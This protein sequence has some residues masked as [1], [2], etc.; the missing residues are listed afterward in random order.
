VSSA[1]ILEVIQGSLAETHGLKPGDHIVS[2][3]GRTL[4]DI[5]DY[6]FC[7]ADNHLVLELVHESERRFVRIE[8]PGFES[9]GLR[10]AT[11]LFDGIKTCANKCVFC[12]IDQL[13]PGMRDAVYV[14]D[15]DFRLSFLYGNFVTLTNMRDDDIDRIIDDRLS[16]L[17]V[18]I[19]AT[20]PELR[21]RMLG[22]KKTDTTLERLKRLSDADIELHIQMVMCPGL[23]DKREL[24]GSIEYLAN[25]YD[26]ITSVGLV[27]VGLTGY[28]QGLY[29]LRSFEK[30]E[31]IE[32]VEQAGVWQD[33]FESEK[34]SAWLYIADEFYITGGFEL[35]PSQHYGDYPQIE[36]GIGL[37]RLFVDEAADM[38]DS[39][40]E[41]E[42]SSDN[43]TPESRI[44]SVTGELFAPILSEIAQTLAHKTGVVIDVIPVRNSYFG[45]KVNV[46]GLLT[47]SDIVT[48]V[49]AWL[50]NHT[51]PDIV[52]VPDIVLNADGLLLDGYTP[53]KVEK[54]IGAAVHI[55]ECSGSGFVDKVMEIVKK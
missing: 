1:E 13:P 11:S 8:N 2:I 26:G 30:Q 22:R 43:T 21:A 35:P 46:T 45:G 12:F 37:S 31:I 9:L 6:Q 40:P 32:L 38:L 41:D 52:L 10:F 44:A 29:P 48:G 39:I 47:G 23:N 51:R 7:V 24:D 42:H 53:E 15:D 28:R 54:E 14:K 16:P 19:H 55:T 33:K 5:L 20:N 18:S 34:G 36:N 50:E 3:N 27:P 17:Y 4:R 25:G 49:E